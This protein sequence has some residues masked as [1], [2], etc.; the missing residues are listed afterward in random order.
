MRLFSGCLFISLLIFASLAAAQAIEWT[1]AGLIPG[2]EV[3]QQGLGA[4]FHQGVLHIVS[5]GEDRNLPEH[6]WYEDGVWTAPTRLVN[7]RCP[8]VPCL[9]SDGQVMHLVTEVSGKQ[10]AHHTWSEGLWSDAAVL[11]DMGTNKSPAMTAAEGRVHVIHC[12]KNT[13]ARRLYYTGNG[14]WG[15]LNDNPIPDQESHVAPGMAVLDGRLYQVHTGHRTKSLWYSSLAHG[16]EWTVARQIPGTSTFRKPDLVEAN[17]KLYVFFSEGEARGRQQAP[18][19]YCVFEDG[20]WSP[21]QVV[22][23]FAVY[24]DVQ[25]VVQPGLPDQIHLLLVNAHG[26]VNHLHT[27]FEVKMAPLKVK[28]MKRR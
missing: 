22:E 11:P 10:L 1:P 6:T 9:A 12:G 26:G 25:A 21:P 27:S 3:R 8:L 20:N 17:G 28:K 13:D 24:G 2:L 7:V 15:W 16:E 23:G 4:T 14:G 18:V 19:A 5:L